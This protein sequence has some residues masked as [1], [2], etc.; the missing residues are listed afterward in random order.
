[1][2]QLEQAMLRMGLTVIRPKADE[3]YD[4][5]FHVPTDI[6]AGAVGDALIA[7][8]VHPGVM[9]HGAKDALVRAE[10]ELK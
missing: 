4:G 6:S 5:A 2:L 7:R 8:C 10:V 1:V 3:P 9:C